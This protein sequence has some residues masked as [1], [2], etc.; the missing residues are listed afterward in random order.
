MTLKKPFRSTIKARL[1]AALQ[2]LIVNDRYL[3]D[4]NLH[5][6]TIVHKFATYLQFMFQSWHVD[7]E[8]NKDQL[9]SKTIHILEHNNP[10][11]HKR[12]V[13]PD[14][15]VHRRGSNQN[16]LIIEAKKSTNSDHESSNYDRQK[17]ACYMQNSGNNNLG[18]KYG[19]YIEFITKKPQVIKPYKIEWI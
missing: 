8:F 3:L 6:R 7:V 10:E 19:C 14:I 5:E 2:M 17:L 16:L 12:S 4:E 1:D 18:Y 11:P 9:D 13:F 15:I